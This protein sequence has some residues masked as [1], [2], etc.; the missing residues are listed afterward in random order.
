MAVFENRLPIT[1]KFEELTLLNGEKSEFLRAE[2]CV[3]LCTHNVGVYYLK[4]LDEICSVI[5]S[6]E[7]I[8]KRLLKGEK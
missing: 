4:K 5:E 3:E 7:S 6:N 2:L 1:I 8:F